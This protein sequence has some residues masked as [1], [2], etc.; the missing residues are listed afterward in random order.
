MDFTKIRYLY[1]HATQFNS[2]RDQSIFFTPGLVKYCVHRLTIQQ[3]HTF[4]F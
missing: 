4:R 1:L 3:R 2:Q